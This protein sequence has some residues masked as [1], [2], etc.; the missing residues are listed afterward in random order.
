[1]ILFVIF[2]GN[3]W[4]TSITNCTEEEDARVRQ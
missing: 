4:F 3:N 1:M 2:Y